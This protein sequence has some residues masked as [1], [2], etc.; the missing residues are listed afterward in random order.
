MIRTLTKVLPQ[1]TNE[2]SR[3]AGT[4]CLWRKLSSKEELHSTS[5]TS[6]SAVADNWATTYMDTKELLRVLKSNGHLTKV[7]GSCESPASIYKT[8]KKYYG[9]VHID[10]QKYKW[11]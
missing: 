6:S 10:N 5:P 8:R 3:G 11:K 2:Y 7:G 1:P 9:Y 4:R